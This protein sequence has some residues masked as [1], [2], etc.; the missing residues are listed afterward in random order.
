MIFSKKHIAIPEHLELNEKKNNEKK[1]R[2]VDE[3]KL[4]GFTIDRK[5]SFM[6]TSRE[7]FPSIL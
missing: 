3:F 7:C 4:R 6:K 2:V 5:L 1:I